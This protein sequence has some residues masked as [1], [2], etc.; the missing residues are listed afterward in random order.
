MD[1]DLA[2]TH[3]AKSAGV[4]V[5]GSHAVGGGLLVTRFID[6]QHG[7]AVGEFGRDPGGE[8]AAGQ[9]MVPGAARE[10][11]LEAV[12]PVVPERLGEGPAVAPLQLHQHALRHRPAQHP[13]V[14]AREADGHRR[15]QRPERRRPDPPA[16]R[17]LHGHL[18]LDRLHARQ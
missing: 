8:T 17:G 12:R 15:H 1:G 5:G 11:V 4:L 3:P 16:Y 18:V 13:R 14:P 6:D 2:Q 7:F 9:V 10:E